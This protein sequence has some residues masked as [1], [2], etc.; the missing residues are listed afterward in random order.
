ML[1]RL[2]RGR[3][4]NMFTDNSEGRCASALESYLASLLIFAVW[5]WLMHPKFKDYTATLVHWVRRSIPHG[6]RVDTNL[7]ARLV[8]IRH[9]ESYQVHHPSHTLAWVGKKT[10][11]HSK[12][13]ACEKVQPSQGLSTLSKRSVS[14][15]S[16]K[17]RFAAEFP[18][19]AAM[20]SKTHGPQFETTTVAGS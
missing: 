18:K 19:F 10:R 9:E 20:T 4:E 11:P 13:I 5:L 1:Q 6:N 3:F 2:W 16:T 14:D 7:P 17:L 8:E 12:R 15:R